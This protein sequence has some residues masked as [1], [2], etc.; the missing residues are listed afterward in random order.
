[1]VLQQE[2]SICGIDTRRLWLRIGPSEERAFRVRPQVNMECV[3]D[4][5]DGNYSDR[6]VIWFAFI[7]FRSML[8]TAWGGF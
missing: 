1:M 5:D 7:P 8:N 6:S 3:R 2:M 4:L